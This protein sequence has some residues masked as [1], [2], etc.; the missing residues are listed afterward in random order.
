MVKPVDP[1]VKPVDPVVKLVDPV[2]KPV[3]PMVKPVD[4][5]VKPVDPASSFPYEIV[6][7][8]RFPFR[9]DDR[10][11]SQKVNNGVTWGQ[12]YKNYFRRVLPIFGEFCLFSASF[13]YFRRLSP[14]TKTVAFS[15]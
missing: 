4:P 11:V 8:H 13:A 5:M 7:H 12:C 3:D 6:V 15:F 10:T 9:R 14:S 1:M 2:V